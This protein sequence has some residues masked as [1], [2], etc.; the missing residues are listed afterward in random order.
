MSTAGPEFNIQK[1][2]LA[3][4]TH[5]LAAITDLSQKSPQLIRAAATYPYHSYPGTASRRKWLQKMGAEG[6][7]SLILQCWYRNAEHMVAEPSEAKDANYQPHGIWLAAVREIVPH[8]H[9]RIIQ[10][11]SVTYK[12]RRRLWEAVQAADPSLKIT[13]ENQ[14]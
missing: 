10:T 14:H 7:A 8:V 13:I 3:L 1:Q 6:F 4:L 2:F 11:W 9:A 5:D 12:R